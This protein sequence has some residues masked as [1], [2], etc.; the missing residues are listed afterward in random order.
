[1][2]LKKFDGKHVGIID[3]NGD[4]YEGIASY[5]SPEFCAAEFGFAGEALDVFD[6]LFRPADVK[7]IRSLEHHHGEWGNFY[8]PYGLIEEEILGDGIDAVVDALGDGGERALRLLRLISDRGLQDGA[9][10][11]DR[12]LR[13]LVGRAEDRAVREEAKKLMKKRT[14]E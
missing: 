3:P 5:C 7:R 4:Y 2:N 6:R 10:K 9:G 14:T 11:L 8:T 1:M 12:A 13:D